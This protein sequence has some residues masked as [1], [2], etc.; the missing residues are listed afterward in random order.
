MIP[1]SSSNLKAVDHDGSDLL[2]AFRNG[3]LYRYFSVPYEKF[4]GLL[5]ASSKGGYLARRI[6]GSHRYRRER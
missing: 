6:K 1:V 5:N 4:V 2:V 3:S